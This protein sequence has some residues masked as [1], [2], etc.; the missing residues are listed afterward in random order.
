MSFTSKLQKGG[1]GGGGQKGGG[2]EYIKGEDRTPLPTMNPHVRRKPAKKT[3]FQINATL[4]FI[5]RNQRRIHC[6]RSEPTNASDPNFT[7]Y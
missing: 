5:K 3:V 1:G 6:L 4:L 2:I 7:R